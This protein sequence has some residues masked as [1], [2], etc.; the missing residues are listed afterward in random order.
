MGALD[1]LHHVCASHTGLRLVLVLL[2]PTARRARREP[3]YPHGSL[4]MRVLI[5]DGD[6]VIG[7]CQS[8]PGLETVDELAYACLEL[9]RRKGVVA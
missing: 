5:N 1:E 7:R 9:L 2:D 6:S 8:E 4:A 3:I